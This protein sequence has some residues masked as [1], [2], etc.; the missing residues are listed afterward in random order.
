MW[1]GS[2]DSACMQYKNLI[3]KMNGEGV[4]VHYIKFRLYYTS[5][6]TKVARNLRIEEVLLRVKGLCFLTVPVLKPP[7]FLMLWYTCTHVF[8]VAVLIVKHL[9]KRCCSR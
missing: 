8:C 3:E 7:K 2:N 9:N 6:C 5:P 4:H 1:S